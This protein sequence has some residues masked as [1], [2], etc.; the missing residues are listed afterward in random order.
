MGFRSSLTVAA[1]VIMAF[2]AGIVGNPV[3]LGGDP[4]F[5]PVDY[6]FYCPPSTEDECGNYCYFANCEVCRQ[7]CNCIEVVC[8]WAC[9]HWEYT[10][11]DDGNITSST[12]VCDKCTDICDCDPLAR[13]VV[14]GSSLRANYECTSRCRH[15]APCENWAWYVRPKNWG[16]QALPEDWD[17]DPDAIYNYSN[18]YECDLLAMDFPLSQQFINE[19]GS[20]LPNSDAILPLGEELPDYDCTDNEGAQII[21]PEVSVD[22]LDNL[23]VV[24]VFTTGGHPAGYDIDY[25]G[26]GMTGVDRMS[27]DGL[28]VEVREYVDD[29]FLLY[30]DPQAPREPD[31]LLGTF[32]A[33]HP[34]QHGF[35]K[36]RAGGMHL[37]P[38]TTYYLRVVQGLH[39][40]RAPQPDIERASGVHLNLGPQAFGGWSVRGIVH[41]HER[42]QGEW[43][44]TPV[45]EAE[46]PDPTVPAVGGYAPTRIPQTPRPYTT[47]ECMAKGFT[48]EHCRPKKWVVYPGPVRIEMWGRA[49]GLTT[50]RLAQLLPDEGRFRWDPELLLAM[51]DSELGDLENTE[52]DEGLLPGGFG[53]MGPGLG[54]DE[55]TGIVPGDTGALEGPSEFQR[56]S[57][58]A[59]GQ[60]TLPTYQIPAVGQ[61][62]VPGFTMEPPGEENIGYNPLPPYPVEDFEAGL[63]PIEGDPL[64]PDLLRVTKIDETRFELQF[65]RYP[66]A[67]EVPGRW[68]SE[69]ESRVRP[70]SHARYYSFGLAEESTVSVSVSSNG[71][72]THLYLRRGG[73][74][75]GSGLHHQRGTGSVSISERLAPGTYTIEV[76]THEPEVIRDFTLNIRGLSDGAAPPG[77]SV[78]PPCSEA[79]TTDG[80]VVYRA[81]P[82]EGWQDALDD[83]EGE[84]EWNFS[85]RWAQGCK[86]Y[87]RVDTSEPEDPADLEVTYARFYAFGLAKEST[88]TITV[89]PGGV[90]AWLYLRSSALRTGPGLHEK[91]GTGT[92]TI[93][94][95]L[96]P[97]T[98]T[99]EVT[100][101]EP[102][103]TGSFTV[104]ITGLSDGAEP[105]V[106][107][108]EDSCVESFGKD[109]QWQA[110]F[111]DYALDD[112]R[113]PFQ[114][115]FQ[116]QL[117]DSN[118]ALD[119][120]SS[121]LPEPQL[122]TQPPPHPVLRLDT[123]TD[124]DL[125]ELSMVAVDTEQWQ[126]TYGKADAT[127]RAK[128]G[129]A[130]ADLSRASGVFVFQMAYVDKEEQ[131]WEAVHWSNGIVAYVGYRS[132]PESASLDWE[133]KA[134]D[135]GVPDT[136]PGGGGRTYQVTVTP[137]PTLE[138]RFSASG[139]P[140]ASRRSAPVIRKLE[141]YETAGD[142]AVFVSP[143]S[144]DFEYRLWPYDGGRVAPFEDSRRDT[145]VPPDYRWKAKTL[146]A[147]DGG[148]FIV[149]VPF[150]KAVWA[151]EVR[152]IVEMPVYDDDGNRMGEE[153][154]RTAGSNV[155]TIVVWGDLDGFIPTPAP[156]P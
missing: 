115:P 108:R 48:Y 149:R 109:D 104:N 47:A 101:H 139:N 124:R 99:L 21:Q 30:P 51:G 129:L 151:F 111:W 38:S 5:K 126:R 89:E 75:S 20:R 155:E 94:E 2:V 44:V 53:H 148:K 27:A 62:G 29:L 12:R 114:D 150:T 97:G 72:D 145:A 112:L 50:E 85:G 107:S 16:F 123:V 156:G 58:P 74:R 23:E 13:E 119:L 76:T 147:G 93:S 6:S 96:P 63:F 120:S 67:R 35:N 144:G 133:V 77:G 43:F 154:V 22:L 39:P 102:E 122:I 137:M 92:L 57:T 88:V 19:C 83:L 105:P 128:H 4:K 26:F 95:N 15:C 24:Q 78:D 11:D 17:I 100:T 69:C 127:W 41:I 64:G 132:L 116:Y 14:P 55:V 131:P 3:E 84:Q 42:V 117:Q 80:T 86:S 52:G 125:D 66:D 68:L 110:H 56:H 121:S 141:Q 140:G 9:W 146:G 18:K 98:Y 1:L 49:T 79:L 60:V 87:E 81:F 34:F 71:I 45:P 65:D 25:I 28:V 82:Y 134:V 40:S 61:V 130:A 36:F 59:A 135:S 46:Y 7:C 113:F 33:P 37:D 91:R 143:G 106:V 138:A 54:G 8:S 142:V 32:P 118:S 152:R 103:V 73:A 10:Y 70:G 90:D 136:S 31:E 153:R